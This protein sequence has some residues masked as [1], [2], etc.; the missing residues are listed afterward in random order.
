MAAKDDLG[1]RGEAIAA[2]HLT[3]SGMQL[4]ERNW[5][6]SQGEIDIVARAGSELVFVEVKTRSGTSF[7]HP[8]E[9]ITTRK[10]ARLRRLAAAWCA[11]HPGAAAGVRIDAIAVLLPRVGRVEIDHVER[12][13]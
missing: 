8:L 9:A 2:E 7:G 5:R 12:I 1:R 3:K 10:L 6:C 4:I 11:A 13:F